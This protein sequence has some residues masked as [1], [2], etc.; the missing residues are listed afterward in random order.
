MNQF[1]ESGGQSI[2]VSAS[3][4]V[5]PK[6]IQDWFPLVGLV[7]S[8]CSPRDSQEFSPTPQFESI[9]SLALS[10]LYGPTI[11]SVH[12]YWKTIALTIRTFVSKVMFLPS[13][14]MSKY[15]IDFLSRRR[16]FLI[17]WLQS[18]SKKIKSVT[19]SIFFPSICHEV[20][21]QILWGYDFP[22]LCHVLSY[23]CHLEQKCDSSLHF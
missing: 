8:P 2:G 18:P 23:F 10:L 15:V 19:V 7:G 3:T 16:H 5:L 13:T 1:F 11:T 20:M 4:S 17:S 6:N 22:C 9:K 12:D 21:G 14:T